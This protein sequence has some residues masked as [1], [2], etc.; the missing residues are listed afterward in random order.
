M[1]CCFPYKDDSMIKGKMVIK[2]SLLREQP[3]DFSLAGRWGTGGQWA[4]EIGR[5]GKMIRIR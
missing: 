1:G 4:R 3:A 5:A 2:Q